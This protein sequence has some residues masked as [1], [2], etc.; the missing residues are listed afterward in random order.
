MVVVLDDGAG[1]SNKSSFTCS[2]RPGE[3]ICIDDGSSHSNSASVSSALLA[4]TTAEQKA[5]SQLA[6]PALQQRGRA[7]PLRRI[8]RPSITALELTCRWSASRAPKPPS[9][10]AI[11]RRPCLPFRRMIC[12]GTSHSVCLSWR[13]SHSTYWPEHIFPAIE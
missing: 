4:P 13:R 3:A 8:P 5:E 12:R 9:R 6:A 10:V 7:Q 1:L 11:P 2:T